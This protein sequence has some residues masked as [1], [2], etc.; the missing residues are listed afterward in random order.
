MKESK[1]LLVLDGLD[2][3][4]DPTKL[5]MYL[6]LAEGREFSKCRIVFTSRHEVGMEFRRFCDTLW[7]IVGF[8]RKDAESFILKYFKHNRP[9]ANK[10]LEQVSP[11]SGSRDLREMMA[12][13]LNTTLLCLLCED[14]QGSFP[15]SRTQLYIEI[16]LCVL[17]RFEQKNN[18]SS[19]NEDLIKFTGKS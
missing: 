11:W 19:T 6:K 12:N 3:V 16:V 17:R 1:V 2:E 14:F 8:T 18:L 13:P 15:T 4:D 7:E 9:L 5:A 10:L